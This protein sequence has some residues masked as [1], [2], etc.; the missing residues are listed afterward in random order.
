MAYRIS[1]NGTDGWMIQNVYAEEFLESVIAFG[2]NGKLAEF[3][4]I[5]EYVHGIDFDHDYGSE[6]YLRDEFWSLLLRFLD[7]TIHDHDF[8]LHRAIVNLHSMLQAV[9]DDSRAIQ[10]SSG[11]NA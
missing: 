10:Q 7:H 6:N 8:H 3:I 5:T 2:A 11:G 4:R 9:R 1:K